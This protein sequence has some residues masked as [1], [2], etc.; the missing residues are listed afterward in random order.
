MGEPDKPS[1]PRSVTSKA[2]AALGLARREHA[3]PV[4]PTSDPH[5]SP[6]QSGPDVLRA[7]SNSS[8]LTE[9]PILNHGHNNNA[10]NNIP[11]SAPTAANTAADG[12]ASA[13][14]ESA[15]LPL[16]SPTRIKNG[17]LRFL[18]HT[19]NALTWSWINILL[20]FVPI[21]IAV[22]IVDLKAEIVFAMNAI[23]IIPL[24]GLLA[25]ATEVCAA[26]VGD[27]WGAF[28]NVSFGNAV[29][30]ILFII[31][32]QSNQLAV[33][34]ASLVGSLLANLLLILGMAFL[35]GGLKY[36]EQVGLNQTSHSM[37]HVN[38]FSGLQ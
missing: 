2:A 33:V 3:Q 4:L 11:P 5:N 7:A 14:L 25:H 13:A 9:K 32:L 37:F 18:I 23:A 38:P 16:W 31:L 22:K 10:A 24:A 12:E 17:S 20:V 6:G 8:T 34:Q 35:L 1:L 36:Q 30:L 28:L 21:G 15:K 26:R 19:K 29:E 27:T